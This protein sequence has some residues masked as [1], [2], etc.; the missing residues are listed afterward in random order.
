MP[1][2]NSSRQ[3]CWPELSLFNCC[4]EANCSDSSHFQSNLSRQ[5]ASTCKPSKQ[6]KIFGK[7]DLLFQ[8]FAV[9]QC[10]LSRFVW[11]CWGLSG[12]FDVDVWI[13]SRRPKECYQGF[14]DF[15]TGGAQLEV[16]NKRKF[17]R[18]PQV[19]VVLSKGLDLTTLSFVSIVIVK[20]T[21]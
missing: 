15:F 8:K 20:D 13:T 5:K 10:C 19:Q 12:Y 21:F 2:K 17:A 18:T 4:N 11:I 16:G 14:L 7:H 9:L 1:K 3:S 6:K